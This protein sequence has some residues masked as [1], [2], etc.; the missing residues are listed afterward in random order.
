M[1]EIIL[2]ITSVVVMLVF[3]HF[4][5]DLFFSKIITGKVSKRKETI[6]LLIINLLKYS[7][8]IVGILVILNIVGIDTASILAGA[9]L[10]G[11]LL[12]FAL[13]KLLQD[14]INGFYI[15]IEN[16]FV[17]GEYVEINGKSGCVLELV[18][19]YHP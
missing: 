11:I 4:I 18:F 2:S 6:I 17:V 13:Q 12:G 1:L 10:I 3:I 7:L 19:L 15:I 16:Q 9:G 8:W 14:M 5:T